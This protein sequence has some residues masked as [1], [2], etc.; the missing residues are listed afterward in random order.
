MLTGTN[1]GKTIFNGSALLFGGCGKPG[2]ALL[3]PLA[4][5]IMPLSTHV[6]YLGGSTDRLG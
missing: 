6:V 4:A 1:N 2:L 3:L 5:E